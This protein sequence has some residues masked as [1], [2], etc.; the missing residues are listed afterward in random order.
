MNRPQTYEDWKRRRS[1]VRAGEDFA[2]RV[3]DRISQCQQQPE[4]GAAS[5]G[6]LA[7]L[8][9]R[10]YVAAALLLVSFAIAIIRIASVVAFILVRPVEGF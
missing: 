9:S 1:A 6:G 3:M 7:R 5:A 8:V 2:D 4:G 10:R